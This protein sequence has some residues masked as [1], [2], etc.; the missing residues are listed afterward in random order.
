M[1]RINILTR[2]TDVLQ[3]PPLKPTPGDFLK[4]LTESIQNRLVSDIPI[5]LLLSGG[6]DSTIVFE[7]MKKFTKDFTVFH[8]ENDE[9][10]YLN[11]LDFKGI[12][13][14]QITLE[15]TNINEAMYWN[16]TPVDLGSVIPQLALSKA[17]K[18]QGINVAISGDGADEIF[19]GYKRSFDY[20]SQQSDI[21]EELIYYHLPRLDKLMMASTV[22]LRSPFLSKSVIEYGLSIPY[23]WRIDKNGLKHMFKNVV[24]KYIIERKKEP[25]RIKGMREN[26]IKW[27][28]LCIDTFREREGWNNECE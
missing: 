10:E 3:L 9:A 8:V 2:E 5:S 16:E 12:K 7:I 27:R 1:I 14:K 26:K 25:L 15:E 17:I 11:H 13:L 20:D 6:I 24:P 22:E 23:E 19:G 18:K 4:I 21:F 28:Q